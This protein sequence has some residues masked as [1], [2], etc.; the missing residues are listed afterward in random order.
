MKKYLS[1]YGTV[2]TL[3]SVFTV[4]QCTTYCSN[5]RPVTP[6]G[7]RCHVYMTITGHERSADTGLCL[8]TLTRDR[9][10]VAIQDTILNTALYSLQPAGLCAM[11]TR[12]RPA[13]VPVYSTGTLGDPTPQCVR[14]V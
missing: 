14:V 2:F 1:I 5:T 11:A 4:V 13:T 12:M 9:T 7:G 8:C 10:A 6:D 3:F